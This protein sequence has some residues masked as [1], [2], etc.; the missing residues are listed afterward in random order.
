MGNLL[1][2]YWFYQY[3]TPQILEGNQSNS[4]F[5]NLPEQCCQQQLQLNSRNEGS[6]EEEATV[7]PS[8]EI[9]PGFETPQKVKIIFSE[10][11][12]FCISRRW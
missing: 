4:T 7:Y 10:N 11:F 6:N 1:S 2:K 5:T 9:K 12:Q 3:S 8:A